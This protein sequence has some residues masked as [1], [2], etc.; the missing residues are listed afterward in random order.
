MSRPMYWSL[1]LGCACL[2]ALY[3][4]PAWS[5]VNAGDLPTASESVE[6][7]EDTANTLEGAMP[8]EERVVRLEHL[9]SAGR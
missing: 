6:L 1:M 9:S 4:R 5:V 3:S 2:V 8:Q 7:I